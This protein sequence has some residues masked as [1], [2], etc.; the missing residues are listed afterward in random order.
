MRKHRAMLFCLYRNLKMLCTIGVILNID[1]D[2]FTTVNS[3]QHRAIM[4][5]IVVTYKNLK[6]VRIL[7]L[8]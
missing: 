6:Q 1:P 3:K 5:L 7:V 8:F 2:S 4:I